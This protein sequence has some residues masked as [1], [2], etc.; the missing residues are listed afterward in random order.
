[1]GCYDS[2]ACCCSGTKDD[3]A[4][5]EI[6][7][8]EAEAINPEALHVPLV[9]SVIDEREI[10]N[11]LKVDN[12]SPAL[13][14]DFKDRQDHDR[15]ALTGDWKS[16]TDSSSFVRASISG[17]SLTDLTYNGQE[18]M[19]FTSGSQFAITGGYGGG[20]A[21]YTPSQI[22]WENGGVYVRVHLAVEEFTSTLGTGLCE[23]ILEE[24][25][26]DRPNADNDLSD[27]EES[28]A[29]PV[30]E[31][32][33]FQDARFKEFESGRAPKPNFGSSLPRRPSSE[34]ITCQGYVEKHEAD[35]NALRD[36]ES[37]AGWNLKKKEDGVEIFLKSTPGSSNLS[38][39]AI[40]EIPLGPQG[41]PYVINEILAVEKRP[42]WDAMCTEAK[43]LES[44]TPYYRVTYVRM[45]SP[46]AII[47]PRDLCLLGRIRFE[48]DGG[49]MM[50]VESINHPDTPAPSGH[51]R[52]RMVRG[53]YIFRYTK[54]KSAVQAMFVGCVDPCGWLPTWIANLVAWKQGLALGLFKKSLRDA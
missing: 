23:P 27:N 7:P 35:W 50:L 22:T 30:E 33:P 20:S 25:T 37:P 9:A 53:G 29:L 4:A 12:P 13:S 1:M 2:K 34:G 41:L 8:C 32:L 36:M 54:D 40:V 15:E 24:S 10:A 49:V 16:T 3:A 39:K 38:F 17:T 28:A 26:T 51:V 46:A 42:E 31:T 44:Y 45:A 47:A 6:R 52:A 43:V 14:V 21:T 18:T 11:H 19:T 5:T 48:D